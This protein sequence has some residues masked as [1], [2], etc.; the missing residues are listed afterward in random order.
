MAV[1]GFENLR[2]FKFYMPS[3]YENLN[4]LKRFKYSNCDLLFTSL[5]SRTGGFHRF[6]GV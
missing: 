4:S 3:D 5:V 1:D 6:R 2:C